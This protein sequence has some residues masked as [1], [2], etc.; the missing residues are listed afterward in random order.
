MRVLASI[1]DALHTRGEGLKIIA[2]VPV[3][4]S[5]Y[6][7]IGGVN[8]SSCVPAAMRIARSSSDPLSLLAHTTGR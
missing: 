5:A 7:Q 8:S 3:P 4:T 6:R 1:H 2:E